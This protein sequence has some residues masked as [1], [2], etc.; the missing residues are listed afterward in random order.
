MT[1]ILLNFSV[2]NFRYDT[3]YIQYCTVPNPLLNIIDGN[4]AISEIL[5]NNPLKQTLET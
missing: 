2:L 3:Q 4:S 5:G 1:M